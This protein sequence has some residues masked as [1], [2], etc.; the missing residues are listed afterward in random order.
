MTEKIEVQATYTN[1]NI[2]PAPTTD[3]IKITS[4]PAGTRIYGNN[5]TIIPADVFKGTT[6]IQKEND[7]W[8]EI[9]RINDT[10][11][12]GHVAVIHKGSTLDLPIIIRDDTGNPNPDPEEPP[13]TVLYPDFMIEPLNPDTGESLGPAKLYRVLDQ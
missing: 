7:K 5:W 8:L 1:T 11:A 10:P 9:T 2:R 13:I 6:L 12:T 3:N 4:V